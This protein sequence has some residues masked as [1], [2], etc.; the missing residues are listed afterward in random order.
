[1]NNTKKNVLS[2]AVISALSLGFSG[3]GDASSDSPTNQTETKTGTFNDSRGVTYLCGST[4]GKTDENATFSYTSNCSNVEFSI[5]NIKLGSIST[6]DINTDGT[7]YPADLLG[8]D[9]NETN[10]TTLVNILQVLQSLDSDNNP[11][12]GITIDNNTETLLSGSSVNVVNL[13]SNETQPTDLT[14]IVEV[15]NKT[16]LNRNYAIAHYEDTLRK[17]INSTVDTVAPAPAFFA[18]TSNI[19]KENNTSVIINGEVG[20]KVFVDKNDTGIVIDSNNTATVYLD[21]TNKA[22]GNISYTI[23]LYDDLNQSSDDLNATIV[24]DTTAPIFT[25][26]NITVDENQLAVMDINSTDAHNVTYGISGTDIA[27]FDIND[28]TGVLTFRNNP[29]YETK[30]SYDLN[31]SATDIIGNINNQNT[32]ISINNLNDTAPVITSVNTTV[33][34]NQLTALTIEKTDADNLAS[35]FTYGISGTDAGSFDINSTTGVLTFKNTPDYEIKASYDVNLTV[36]DNVQSTTKAIIITLNNLNDI[37]PVITTSNVTVDENQLSALTIAKTDEDN[38]AS[39]FTYSISGTDAGSFDINSTTGLLTFK[40]NPDYENKTSYDL[41]LTVNDG[42]NSTNKNITVNIE[43]LDDVV[44]SFTTNE[45]ISLN[46]NSSGFTVEASD[47]FPINYTL[48]TTLDSAL[49]TIDSATGEVSFKNNPDYENPHDSGNNNT[50]SVMVKISDT[51][52]AHTQEKLFVVT[53]N[54]LDDVPTP[55]ASNGNT[56]SGILSNGSAISGATIY[57]QAKDKTLR[58]TTSDNNGSYSFDTSGL[59]APFMFFATMPDSSRLYSYN[60]GEFANTN[61]TPITSLVLANV[62]QSFNST[63]DDMFIDFNTLNNTNFTTY[64]SDANT[65]IGGNFTA[66]LESSLLTNFNHFYNTFSYTGYNYDRVL[67]SYDTSLSYSNVA[68]RINNSL[69]T[70]ITDINTSSLSD[71]NTSGSVLDDNGV[72]IS[73]VTVSVNYEINGTRYDINTTTD[74]NGLYTVTVPNYRVYNMNIFNELLN[75]RYSNLNTFYSN[76]ATLQI[77]NIN[78]VDSSSNIDASG[79]IF[80]GR[81]NDKITEATVN[82]REGYNNKSGTILSTQTTSNQGEFTFSSLP[83]GSYTIEI[84]KDGFYPSYSNKVFLTSS[85]ALN[86]SILAD[87]R[88]TILDRDAFAT[89]VLT[90]GSSPSDLDSHLYIAETSDN[91]TRDE[92][93]YSDKI[94]GSYP[95][96]NNNPCATSG[97]IASLD[98]DDTSGNGPETTSICQRYSHPIHFYVRN[99]SGSSHAN[100]SAEAKVIVRKFDGSTYE[101]VPPSTNPNNYNYWKVFDVDSSGNIIPVNEYKSSKSDS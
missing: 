93:Y 38:L 19:T 58:T 10:S 64:F 87:N 17:E 76:L 44:P 13:D 4:T 16:L 101:I 43:N 94:A 85:S 20:A 74:A 12:N 88:S 27:S 7:V 78:L 80:N 41:N 84:L 5:G 79:Y 82:I 37:S 46:E 34:E 81:T 24:K 70:T 32:I 65:L 52:P 25:L 26:S 11:N 51:I 29:D 39:T 89:I 31:I 23:N 77:A 97:V 55:V 6:N 30:T 68:L 47:D 60:N 71:M 57:L 91:G 49:F 100:V 48:G 8:I 59:T 69:L 21:T 53:I 98:L 33:D 90:W 73:G 22:D 62:A 40:N 2:L 3:C 72:A 92:V 56:I 28:T 99:Y 66:S 42:V 15:V 63:L 50:Y 18:S 61:I 1:L 36:S 86:L 75:M 14:T 9:R 35:T 67:Q 45:S 96:D 95:S 54:N 83:K